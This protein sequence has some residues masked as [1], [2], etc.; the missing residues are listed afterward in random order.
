MIEEGSGRLVD[1]IHSQESF[2][3]ERLFDIIE[4]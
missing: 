1:N 3:I 4:M 2:F